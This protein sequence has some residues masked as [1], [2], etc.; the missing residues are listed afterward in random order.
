MRSGSDLPYVTYT[1]PHTCMCPAQ[2]LNQH[3][4]DDSELYIRN[5]AKYGMKVDP[6]IVIALRSKWHVMH[7]TRGFCEGYL[8]PLAG[9]LDRNPH[10]RWVVV[11]CC[12]VSV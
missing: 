5:C 8:L 1:C 6:S 7:P 9:I 12:M 10:I 4:Q 11:Q 2:P 3:H